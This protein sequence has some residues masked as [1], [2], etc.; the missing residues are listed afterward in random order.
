MHVG[1]CFQPR[2]FHSRRASEVSSR[3]SFNKS[4]CRIRAEAV[5]HCLTPDGYVT[6]LDDAEDAANIPEVRPL[7]LSILQL[8]QHAACIENPAGSLVECRKV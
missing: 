1:F 4:S 2:H 8:I 3:P 6:G 7:Q 5:Y